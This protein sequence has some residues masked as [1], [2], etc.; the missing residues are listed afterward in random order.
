MP[1]NI[2]GGEDLFKDFWLLRSVFFY[3]EH[4][5]LDCLRPPVQQGVHK[6]DT[7]EDAK[8]NFNAVINLKAVCYVYQL[9]TYV[10]L[11]FIISL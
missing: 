6:K 4:P 11:S 7:N 3:L 9:F 5:H 2:V 1:G 8:I 10:V